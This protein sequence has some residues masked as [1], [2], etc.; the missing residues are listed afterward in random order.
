MKNYFACLI[1]GLVILEGCQSKAE[2][3]NKEAPQ[4]ITVVN[5]VE[6]KAEV[7]KVTNNAATILSKKEV[8][9]LCY[10]NIKN[11]DAS[12]G[13]M[14]KVYSVKPADFAA[15]MKALSVAGY[16]TILPAQL[17]EYLVHDGP[18]PSKPIMITFDDTRGEQYSIGAAEM[19]KYG[20]KGVFFVMTVSINRPNYLSKEQIKE[21]SDTGNVIA[22]HTW[23]HHMVTKYSGDDWNTQLVKPKAKLEEITGTPV[24]Y[25]AYPF[26]LWNTAAI[27]EIKKSGYQMAFILSTKRDSIDPLYTIRRMIVSGTWNTEG[28][29]KATESTF[30]K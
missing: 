29:M 8:P 10:H 6:Q 27:P 13:P 18:L 21:L 12:A 23:D 20:F 11:F 15:Q 5:E 19:E 4:K 30:T 22:A 7:Q 24:S 17:Y 9:I 16:H 2:E 25:F 14:T 1:L 26:G 28:M 3:T